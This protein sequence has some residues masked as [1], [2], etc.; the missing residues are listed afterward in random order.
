MLPSAARRTA[1]WLLA[2]ATGSL[3]MAVQAQFEG[4]PRFPIEVQAVLARAGCNMGACHGNLNG[5]GGFRLSLRGEDP[6]RDYEWLVRQHGQRRVNRLAP[7][8][9]LIL[10]KPA[11][12]VAHEGGVRF[13]PGSLEYRLLHDWI[14][15]GVPQDADAPR[16]ERLEV[17][18][19]ER[20]VVAPQTEVPLRV[21]AR[22][23]DGSTQDVTGLS[24]YEPS[25]LNVTVDS[26]GIVH[27]Q[28]DGETTVIVRFLQAQVPVRLAFLPQRARFRWTAPP[29]NNFVDRFVFDKLQR[30]Q[31]NP[32]PLCD[33]TA[34]VRRAYLD[35]LGLPPT[36]DQA[37]RFLRDSA[38]DKRQ[39]LVDGLLARPEFA[40]QWALKWSD[41][42]RNEEKVLDPRGVD[43][44]YQWM[45]DWFRRGEPLDAFVRALV[46]A[47]GSTYDVPP[48]NFYRALRDPTTRGETA[49][50]LFLGV[51]LQCARCHNHPFDRWT[52]DD[53]YSWAAL[54][55]RIDYK[56]VENKRRDRFDKH[57]FQGE[58]IVLVKS[59]GEVQNPRTGGNAPPRFLGADGPPLPDDADR[60][61]QLASWLT[62]SE[63][64]QFARAQANLVW[65]HLL[66]R[67]LVEPIDDFRGT[68]P[69]SHPALL[70]ALADE[71]IRHDFRLRPLVRT[72]M[73]SATYQLAATPNPTNADDDRNFSRAVV[74]RLA[75]EKLLDAQCRALDVPPRFA[76]HRRGLRAGQLPGVRRVRARDASL[77]ADDRFLR[78]F[79]KPERL[80]A[81]EC[82]RSNETTLSQAFNLI[83][84]AALH[85]RLED[86]QNRLA[87]LARSAEPAEHLVTELYWWTLSRPPNDK[88]RAAAVQLLA[89][90]GDRLEGLQD[91]AWALLNSKES[92][93]RH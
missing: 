22:F 50:R 15:R 45:R 91:V 52:Q 33:D 40:E 57:E 86:P 8:A 28:R 62:D 71:L 54:F 3:P 87:R 76:G 48:A 75:A 73:T 5:K 46:A 14:A 60:L 24:V 10:L 18:P 7:A 74:R 77:T 27:R 42:L 89:D 41:L 90:A 61:E 16:L 20:I 51:R 17:E 83:G 13:R 35:A 84:G 25:N 55:G 6:G 12:R 32:S 49:A 47:R 82:E 31:I 53:Y 21:V 23:S 85:Q 9:S 39:R 26:D 56:I 34:F 66:G 44:Y 37:R 63:N 58:Q 78:T 30:L 64:R 88:E 70:E 65:Y 19:R 11:G 92:V 29:A 43:V 38:P 2:V 1:L 80:L 59:E 79:G 67:G 93:F 81:C 36:A 68:N 72:I 4:P 69:P